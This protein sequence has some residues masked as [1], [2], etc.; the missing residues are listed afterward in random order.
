[1][2]KLSPETF[3]TIYINKNNYFYSLRHIYTL[4]DKDFT[5]DCKRTEYEAKHGE[6]MMHNNII[7]L[8]MLLSTL[9]YSM[10]TLML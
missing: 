10:Q 4:H 7:S 9:N 2:S 1:M 5:H 6:Q 3:R 8:E